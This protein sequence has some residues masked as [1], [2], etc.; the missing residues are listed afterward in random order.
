M[1]TPVIKSIAFSAHPQATTAGWAAVYHAPDIIP[2]W[3]ALSL[4]ACLGGITT[5]IGSAAN[6]VVAGIAES[7]GHPITFV[8]YLKYGIPIAFIS[9]LIATLWLWL[10]FL[11]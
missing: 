8:R 7:S 3:W 6:V 11:R 1:M 9:L 5:I 10:L 2:L 4:G